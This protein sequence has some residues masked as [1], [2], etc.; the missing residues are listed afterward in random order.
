MCITASFFYFWCLIVFGKQLL[1]AWPPPSELECGLEQVLNQLAYILLLSP[2]FSNNLNTALYPACP[3][4]S[5]N[6]YFI[7]NLFIEFSSLC[8]CASFKRPAKYCAHRILGTSGMPWTSLNIRCAKDSVLGRIR[9]I[10]DLWTVLR[11]H[12][13]TSN[14]SNSAW[15]SLTLRSILY[16]IVL[17]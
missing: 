12:L 2:L 8:H 1:G 14:P 15:R 17:V 9:R 10:L 5:C 16:C 6:N 7:S 11:K 3:E 4:F 13:T